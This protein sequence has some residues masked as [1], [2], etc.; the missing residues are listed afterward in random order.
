MFRPQSQSA[1]GFRR[2]DVVAATK[3]LDHDED[4]QLVE[5][6][7]LVVY[8]TLPCGYSVKRF[9]DAYKEQS[10]AVIKIRA[11]P[12]PAGFEALRS[13]VDE[14]A[15]AHENAI[16]AKRVLRGVMDMQTQQAAIAAAYRPVVPASLPTG[17]AAETA[18]ADFAR[19]TALMQSENF[20]LLVRP[21]NINAIALN[22]TPVN[23]TPL[24]SAFLAFM[25]QP[26]P[27]LEP[28]QRSKVMFVDLVRRAVLANNQ[29][30]TWQDFTAPA[31]AIPVAEAA[32]FSGF[33][34]SKP[35]T[36]PEAK[37]FGIPPGAIP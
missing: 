7:P 37:S 32:G 10:A 25:R 4:E 9:A 33:M 20:A 16:K 8:K 35:E 13:N 29:A 15:R 23:S 3:L 26:P 18:Y 36:V 12:V 31:A 5:N 2:S 22:V 34:Q 27:A 17:Q 19:I 24:F 28:A 6:E 30:Y 1:K 14:W 21:E 11:Q